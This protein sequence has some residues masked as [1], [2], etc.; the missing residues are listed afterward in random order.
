VPIDHVKLPVADLDA[1]RAFYSAALAPLGYRLVL[2]E[3]PWLAFRV[4]DGSDDEEAFALERL[5]APNVRTHVAFTASSTA[6][7]DEFHAAALAAGTTARRA[8]GRTA[9]TTT[10]PSSSTP[11]A[12]TSRP[13]TTA[14]PLC[15]PSLARAPAFAAAG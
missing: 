3:E 7:V 10:P 1:S 4:G 11:R 12:T 2:D 9:A 13:S 8:S 14:V 15:S 6:E 5:G